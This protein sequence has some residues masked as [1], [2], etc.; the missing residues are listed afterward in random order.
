[1]LIVVVFSMFGI[2][3][4]TVDLYPKVTVEK[5]LRKLKKTPSG[6]VPFERQYQLLRRKLE[7]IS[8]AD[9]NNAAFPPSIE[10]PVV[11][12]RSVVPSTSGFIDLLFNPVPPTEVTVSRGI[13]SPLG[14]L[15][16]V[17]R[18]TDRAAIVSFNVCDRH[19]GAANKLPDVVKGWVHKIVRK[20]LGL[21]RIVEARSDESPHP[22]VLEYAFLKIL[23]GQNIAV[24]P[25]YLSPAAIT[26][27]HMKRRMIITKHYEGGTLE[28]YMQRGTIRP[29]P[30]LGTFQLGYAVFKL[31]V[32]LHSQGIA[33]GS[34]SLGNV[35][36][37]NPH[38]VHGSVVL[39]G[40]E[41]AVLDQKGL[42]ILALADLKM[43]FV[44]LMDLNITVGEILKS[45]RRGNGDQ[46]AVLIQDIHTETCLK[47]IVSDVDYGLIRNRMKSAIK[48]LS[49]P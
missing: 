2:M 41:K 14:D 42:D 44:L 11:C 37:T 1:M 27:N 19:N 45:D 26:A 24:E 22:L 18:V 38:D 16:V 21:L 25:I 39:S 7:R 20:Q 32:R 4:G 3:L 48:L 29:I 13:P 43:F 47:L 15:T 10:V 34:I 31:I 9:M 46:L 6:N 49:E 12:P 30:L 23:K 17:S 40:F 36:I 5:K 33:H 35:I 8:I 28:E